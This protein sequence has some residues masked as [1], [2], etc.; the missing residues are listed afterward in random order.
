MSLVSIIVPVYNAE[1]YLDKCIRSV[2]IQTYYNWELFLVNDG[3][4]DDSLSILYKYAYVDSRITVLD[5][6]KSGVSDA[7]N[8]ALN[9]VKGDYIIFLDA[10]DYWCVNTS[11]EILVYFAKKYNL[12]ITRGDYLRVDENDCLIPSNLDEERINKKFYSYKILDSFSFLKNVLNNEFYLHT[13]LF[14]KKIINNIRFES[15]RIFVEDMA[16]Y[17]K[18]CMQQL[19]CMYLSNHIFYAYRNNFQ[20]ISNSV[21]IL[22]LRDYLHTGFLIKSLSSKTSDADL[23]SYYQKKSLAIYCSTLKWLTFDDYFKYRNDFIYD[24]NLLSKHKEIKDWIRINNISTHYFIF[25]LPIS[26]VIKLYR[27]RYILSKLKNV[28][29]WN[30]QQLFVHLEQQDKSISSY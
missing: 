15:G 30:I 26:F 16:F 23:R 22:K 8:F 5:K 29:R 6:K 17:F 11:L 14:D 25:H 27:F 12:D 20:S 4:T 3:S 18:I 9:K 1:K 7:R 21:N 24:N 2:L 28:L 13:S 10:D 19:H